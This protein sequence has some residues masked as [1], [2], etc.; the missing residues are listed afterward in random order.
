LTYYYPLLNRSLPKGCYA[1]LDNDLRAN[2]AASMTDAVIFG[3]QGGLTSTSFVEALIGLL[4]RSSTQPGSQVVRP[5]KRGVRR[6]KSIAGI[7]P[8]SALPK[9]LGGDAWRSPASSGR[10]TQGPDCFF[11]FL[12]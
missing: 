8:S 10:D 6:Q 1:V 7:G 5:R 3:R 12:F 9:D 11:I 4:R 2:H